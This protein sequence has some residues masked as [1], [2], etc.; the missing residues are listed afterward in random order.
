MKMWNMQVGK[1]DANLFEI[2]QTLRGYSQTYLKIAQTIKQ[3][4]Q[5][6]SRLRTPK[7]QFLQT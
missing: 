4:S 3:T 2:A 6:Y 5:T 1:K 7:Q